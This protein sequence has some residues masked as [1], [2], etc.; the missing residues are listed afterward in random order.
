MAQAIAA[1]VLQQP[2]NARA[3]PTT[4][5][6]KNYNSLFSDEFPISLY[7][8][9]AQIVKR[10]DL[11]LDGKGI[12]QGTKL[13]LIFYLAMYATCAALK[14]PKP[15][16]KPISSLDISLLTDPLLDGCYAWLTETFQ[17]LGGDDKTAKGSTLTA[18]LKERISEDYG[19]KRSA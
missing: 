6:Q 5:A 8:K 16:R 18:A 3:R 1:I 15:M 4:V 17:N 2:D 10:I 11:F 13:N 7:P 14:S 9:C 19:K 12:A